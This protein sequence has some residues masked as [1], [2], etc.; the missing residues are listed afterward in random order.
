MA[1]LEKTCDCGTETYTDAVAGVKIVL[2]G[3]PTCGDKPTFTVL[4]DNKK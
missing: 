4:R 1:K 2:G 3:C